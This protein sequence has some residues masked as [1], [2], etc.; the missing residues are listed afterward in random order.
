M[1][2]W[3]SR[4]TVARLKQEAREAEAARQAARVQKAKVRARGPAVK[5]MVAQLAQARETNRL[6]DRIQAVFAD[7]RARAR[8]TG[9][10]SAF[11]QELRTESDRI[12]R[13][14]DERPRP[15]K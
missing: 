11:A 8:T 13:D 15:D 14:S 9:H 2:L 6:A 10:L 1:R 5:D 4:Q 3:Q 12:L 7:Q